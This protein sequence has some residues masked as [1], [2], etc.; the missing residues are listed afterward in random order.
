MR[1]HSWILEWVWP[2]F[3]RLALLSD[4]YDDLDASVR[5]QIVRWSLRPIFSHYI[6]SSSKDWVQRRLPRWMVLVRLEGVGG[7]WYRVPSMATALHV[8]RRLEVA[9][10]EGD[11]I[12]IVGGAIVARGYEDEDTALC[13]F[14]D[15][16]EN[17]GG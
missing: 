2:S 10:M 5:W 16:G 9:V 8:W 3:R 6:V 13:E 7:G 12:K 4:A 1:I 11:Y 14:W 17:D 15:W